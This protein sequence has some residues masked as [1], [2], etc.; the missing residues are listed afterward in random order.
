MGMRYEPN[1]A[2]TKKRPINLTIRA[3]LI[4]QAKE[5]DLNASQAAETGIAAAIKAAQEKA[6]REE[7]KAAIRAYNERI[8]REGVALPMR[9]PD[10]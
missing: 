10:D 9:W 2:E 4:E 3:D 1:D 5:L 8:A 6:W 7:N